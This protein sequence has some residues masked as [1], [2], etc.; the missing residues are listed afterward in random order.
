MFGKGDFRR[1]VTK[2]DEIARTPPVAVRPH[3]YAQTIA[4]PL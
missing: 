3:A 4:L 1:Q 2:E